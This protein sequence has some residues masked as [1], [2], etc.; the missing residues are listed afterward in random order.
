MSGIA[1]DNIE[2]RP[3]RILCL[4]G[5]GFLGLYSVAILAELEQT[6][7]ASLSSRFNLITG[8]SVGGIIA[9]GIAAGVP[10]STIRDAFDESAAKIFS[11]RRAPR[12][13]VG[14]FLDLMRSAFKPKY[15]NDALRSVIAGLVGPD[16][17]MRDLLCPVLIPAV[18]LTKGGPQVF[19]TP[20][21]LNFQRDMKL[22][23]VDVALATSA[24]P[25]YFPIAEIG[26]ALYADGGLFAN[27]P[28]LMA[29][30][31]AE[32]FF[33]VSRSRIQ[34][35]SIGTTSSSFSFSHT[36]SRRLGVVGWAR[37]AR[38][39]Q[40]ML[41]SQQTMT[42]EMMRHALGDRYVRIDCGQS[43]EQQQD[44]ALD[45]ATPA[46]RGTL[47]G[48]AEVSVREWINNGLVRAM[49]TEATYPSPMYNEIPREE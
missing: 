41:A 39:V 7:G 29:V 21:H 43:H 35:L 32:N 15:G 2:D 19:K 1:S 4:S 11:G 47:K 38:L 33:G 34:V 23:V 46:A 24:A 3:F 20:H 27:S 16:L 31:E 5:G 28:D 10:A 49:L 44:L 42:H 22:R 8:T 36:T 17:L 48:L 37:G 6:F 25:T 45:V 30:H 12:T 18:N 13:A 40:A 9:L 14:S 26:S